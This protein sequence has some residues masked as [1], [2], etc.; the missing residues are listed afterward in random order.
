MRVLIAEDSALL[1]AGLRLLLQE[2]G[3]DVVA[4]LSSVEH[5]LREMEHSE[6]DLCVLDVRLP[7]TYS[8]EG[9]RAAIALRKAHPNAPLLVLSQ[10]V[11]SLAARELFAT[12]TGGLGY[13]LKDR[14]AD[15]E[16]FLDAMTQVAA[17]GSVLDPEVVAQLLVRSSAGDPLAE[18]TPRELD[19][20]ALLAA[21]RSNAGI[22][23]DLFITE[24]AV[25]KHVRNIFDK[26]GLRAAADQNR[27]VRAAI[28]WLT[29]ARE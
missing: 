23:G 4:E 15:V 29:S 6:A 14:I 3:H 13:L 21:G 18:L 19:V 7:P 2:E 20:L 27:R 28:T 25:E 8:D 10:Y 1:R 12:G 17:G 16:A 11:E 22:A 24:G 26:L 9:L 5:L